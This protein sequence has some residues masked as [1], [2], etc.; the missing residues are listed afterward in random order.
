VAELAGQRQPDLILLN[1]DDLG[2][3]IVRFDPRSLGTLT[4]SISA[5]RDSLS[6]AVCWTALIDMARQAELALPSFTRVVTAAM[7]QESSISILQV[8]HSVTA[9]LLRL[10]G[11]PEGAARSKTELA[12]AGARLL[13][14]AAPGSD[15]QLAWAQLLSWTATS[16]G[17]L[18]LVGGLLDGD[19]ELPGLAVDADLRW[20][21]LRR[22]VATGRAGDAQID[23][24]LARDPTDAGR[25]YA[26]W[27]VS[28]SRISTVTASPGR[29]SSIQPPTRSELTVWSA[30]LHAHR[31][32]Y[33][34]STPNPGSA[35][36]RV[37]SPEAATTRPAW[38]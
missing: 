21:L 25:R 29:R 19:V 17:Q 11:D 27:P 2:Y 4:E 10:S 20:A 35:N 12:T 15:Q 6:R 33:H 13:L 8:L 32:A 37:T 36:D 38:A 24:E 3:A 22:L 28:R 5:L 26:L 18:D 34:R 31:R 1:D 9:Q 7:G 14:A 16:P 30:W 23:A